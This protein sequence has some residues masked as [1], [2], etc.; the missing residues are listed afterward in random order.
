MSTLQLVLAQ[1]NLMVGDIH[2]NTDQVVEVAR[3]AHREHGADLVLFPELTLCGYPPEDLLLRPS[4]QKR[5]DAALVELKQAGLPCAVLVGYP[6]VIA[7]TVLNMA[8]LIQD[9]ELVAEYAKQ[10]LPNYQ[11]FDEL[12]YFVPGEQP[13][14]IDINGIPTAITICEDIWHPEPVVQAERAGARLMLNINASPF[15]RGKAQERLDLLAR[16]AQAGKM[17]IVY[18]N[19]VGGQDELVF[20]GGSF[21]VD[22]N[23]ELRARAPEF[24]ESLLPVTVEADG[25]QVTLAQGSDAKPLDGLASVYQALVLGV[26]DYVNKNGF[27]GVVLGLSGGIDSALTLAV[28]VDALGPDRVEAVMMPFRYTSDLSKN[29][30]A[31]QAKRLGIH[32]RVIGIEGIFDASMKALESEFAGSERDTTEENLQA[33][34]RGMLLMA[35]SN[36][37]G[38]MVL[39]T[40]NKSEMSVGYATLYGDMVGGFNALK[41]VP[42]IL[43]YELSRYRNTVSPVIPETVITR[44]PSAELA[45]DQVDSDSLPPYDVLDEIL[46]LY[47][48]EDHSAAYIIGK[49]FDEATVMRVVRLV[50]RNEYKRRQAAVGVRISERGFG[51]DRRYPITNGWKAGE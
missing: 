14:V 22:R 44:E 36:K 9:G 25:D 23:G 35:I 11:V 32:Y 38:F 4:M 34:A 27:K 31:D 21:A 37:K 40:G 20:D 7:G 45:P 46:R 51:R 29:D 33:R 47:I 19:S 18:V 6:R 3:R 49:G 5:I 2:G 42:K 15:H 10:K 24:V 8:G 39:T 1:I 26:R 41:D 48:D 12:R 13:C 50:D 16:Q 17:P 28:A 43:V 30:A